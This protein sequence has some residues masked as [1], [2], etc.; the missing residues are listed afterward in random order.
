MEHGP[1]APV[2][3]SGGR[4]APGSKLTYE[5]FLAWCDEDTWAEWVDGEVVMVTPASDRHQALSG[6]L[7]SVLAIY[8][9][10]RG[11]GRVLG[12]PFQMRL[13]EPVHSGRE[14]DVFFIATAHLPRLKETYLDG[15]AD[16]VVEIISPES[17]L[18]DRGEKFAE[19]QMGGVGEYWLLDPERR[20]A[21]FYRLDERGRYRLSE[22]DRGGWYESV[23]LPGFRLKLEWLWQIPLPRV[24]DVV[25]ELGLL[26][27]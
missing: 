14:P 1:R 7:E 23:T 8:A 5:E 9:E 10:E 25:R 3:P 4:V 12:A 21:D 26:G 24:L 15:P 19:Y 20:D 11:L 13:P 22:P 16:L 6:F 18:R 2:V 27:G 17:R